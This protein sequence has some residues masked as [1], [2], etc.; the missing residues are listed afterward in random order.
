MTR[1]SLRRARHGERSTTSVSPQRDRIC[2]VPA[3]LA[4]APAEPLS[5]ATVTDRDEPESADPDRGANEGDAEARAADADTEGTAGETAAV[6]DDGTPAA[7]GASDGPLPP[8]KIATE[9]IAVETVAAPIT[10]TA[11]AAERRTIQWWYVLVGLLVVEFW[12]YGRRGYIEVCVGTE[13]ET[14]FA[15]VGKERSDANRWAFP[16]CEQRL[17]IGLFSRY[18][19]VVEEATSV[20]CRGATIFRHQGEGKAC[21][22]QEGKWV[23]KIDARQVPPWHAVFYEHLFWFLH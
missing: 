1:C 21:T 20:A 19:E 13:G 11:K 6:A 3:R 22:K 17:N 14:D 10:A 15:L 23:R 2:E 18:D 4:R 16:R 5:S 12:L 8:S 7:A 9:V